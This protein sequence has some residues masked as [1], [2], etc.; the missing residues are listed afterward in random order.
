MHAINTLIQPVRRIRGNRLYLENG[1]RVL[2]LYLDNGLRILSYQDTRVKMYAKNAIEKG[3][4]SSYPGLYEKRFTKALNLFLGEHHD[5][6][7][8]PNENAALYLLQACFNFSSKPRELWPQEQKDVSNTES[9]IHN[10]SKFLVYRVRPFL[11]LPSYGIGVFT[12]PGPKPITSTVLVFSNKTDYEKALECYTACETLSQV[13]PIQH[14]IG[15]RS[16]FSLMR[17]KQ[18]GYNE[19]HWA[20][21]MDTCIGLFVGNGPYIYPK[22]IDYSTFFSMALQ[23]HVLIN[24]EAGSPSIIPMQ[25]SKGEIDKLVRI[26]LQ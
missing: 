14:Y 17:L 13:A 16:L 3:L 11:S 20:G 6:I 2:D 15:A 9:A 19:K 1:N 25:Y 7:T 24:P 4:T 10:S 12:V 5:Y 8:V 22:T 23:A 18:N 21:F 26:I